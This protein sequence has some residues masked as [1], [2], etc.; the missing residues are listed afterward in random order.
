MRERILVTLLA[1]L[2]LSGCAINSRWAREDCLKNW[3]QCT[4]SQCAVAHGEWQTVGF[5]QTVCVF[6]TADGGKAC[7]DS[8]ECEHACLAPRT[9]KLGEPATGA[10]GQWVNYDYNCEIEVV[11]GVTFNDGCLVE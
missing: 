3:E 8:S 4:K 2:L 6:P 9:A 11:K 1:A 5:T 7:T 10:C